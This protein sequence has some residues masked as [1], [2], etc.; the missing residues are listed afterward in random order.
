[1]KIL[2]TVGTTP[3][4]SLIESVLTSNYVNR[5]SFDWT[6][7]I[8][9]MDHNTPLYRALLESGHELID[10]YDV[11]SHTYFNNF[12]LIVSHAGSGSVFTAL[13]LEKK[14][15]VV[16]NLERSDHHQS[17]LAD[18]LSLQNYCA[19][20]NIDNFDSALLRVV[21]SKGYQ[22]FSEQSFDPTKFLEICE[23]AL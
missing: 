1:M 16:P 3:F 2:V 6:L 14:L 22:R 7:Q 21:N 11:D 23:K 15:L 13:R 8:G 19:V 18:W 9:K 5:S 20:S 12:D 4:N 10:F 17:D